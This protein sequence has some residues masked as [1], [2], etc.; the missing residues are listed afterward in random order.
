MANQM[1]RYLALFA[2]TPSILY[3]VISNITTLTGWCGDG[4]CD[5]PEFADSCP[6]DCGES[7]RNPALYS[8]GEGFTRSFWRIQGAGS[9]VVDPMT[10][11][12]T[13]LLQQ[14]GMVSQGGISLLP[15]REYTLSV[16]ASVGTC[17]DVFVHSV[18]SMHLGRTNVSWLDFVAP[19]MEQELTVTVRGNCESRLGQVSLKPKPAAANVGWKYY[20]IVDSILDTPMRIP[21]EECRANCIADFRCCAWQVCPE[22]EAEGCQGC[23][24]LG[25]RPEAT[26][27]D[28]KF[29]WHAGIVRSSAILGELSVESCRAWLLAQSS[30]E[31]DFYDS[32]SGKLQK[33]V[34]CGTVIRMDNLVV[35]KQLFVGGVH[36]PTVVVAN[37]RSPTP[38]WE[39]PKSGRVPH[40]FALPFYDT[41]IGNV[42][43]HSSTMNIVQSY[44]MQ[45]ALLPG[46]VFVDVGANLGSYTVPISEHLGPAGMV[47]SFEPF[48]WLFQLLNA[49]IAL[50]GL[51]NCWA[52][53]VAISDVPVR[54]SLR[55]PNLRHFSSPGGVKVEDQPEGGSEMYDSEWGTEAVDAWPLDDL[56]L[57]DHTVFS[58]RS[59]VGQV[60]LIKIDVEGMEANVVRGALKVLQ[61]FQPIVWSENVGWFEKKDPA[62]LNLME[63]IG[64]RCWKSLSA[65]NDL[66]CEPRSGLRSSRLAKVAKADIDRA[67]VTGRVD[68]D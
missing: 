41:N 37:H 24:L 49:N 16:N 59:R 25:R 31:S 51:M 67:E 61:K 15:G 30:H 55:Q 14:G 29:G 65:G 10:N 44:E 18:S 60:D 4:I 50:N 63:E 1:T 28:F 39:Q 56:L 21:A 40:F 48:R 20:E 22:S 52:F 57:G 5:S 11:Q 35:K 32:K 47:I 54:L 43:K 46:D 66:V 42:I 53:Q 9:R 12:T 45:S 6:T 13:F 23:Y 64:Y 8:H 68:V 3:A 38:R 62:F 26:S 36:L 2:L 33:Y 27:A 34:D 17:L 58:S 7:I 19:E